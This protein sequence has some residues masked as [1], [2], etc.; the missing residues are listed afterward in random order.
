MKPVNADAR[1]RQTGGRDRRKLFSSS[2]SGRSR[3][4][5]S[6]F[7]A[8]GPVHGFW[9]ALFATELEFVDEI[10]VDIDHMIETHD[11]VPAVIRSCVKKPYG[12][13][14]CS[15]V[16]I[17]PLN[18]LDT[19]GRQNNV[20]SVLTNLCSMERVLQ[21]AANCFCFCFCFCFASGIST[22]SL[23]LLIFCKIIFSDCM[24]IIT[25]PAAVSPSSADMFHMDLFNAT[26]EQCTAKDNTL[27]SPIATTLNS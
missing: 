22:H 10:R 15:F 21:N 17:P 23:L 13:G 2:C 1:V 18:N 3:S 19:I 11:I 4:K 8:D 14:L 16:L 12:N 6:R 24:H 26:Q 9:C 5:R 20:T 7:H 25:H 27:N